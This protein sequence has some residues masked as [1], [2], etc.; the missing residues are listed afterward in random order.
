MHQRPPIIGHRNIAPESDITTTTTSTTRW[1]HYLHRMNVE[2]SLQC[3]QWGGGVVLLMEIWSTVDTRV[4]AM[5]WSYIQLGGCQKN[6]ASAAGAWS[7]IQN[8]FLRRRIL[9]PFLNF[10]RTSL[11]TQ[12]YKDTSSRSLNDKANN[13]NRRLEN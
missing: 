11:Q 6:R 9:V 2:Q 10:M 13:T 7:D 8:E 12:N 4:L 3:N 1:F 5:I